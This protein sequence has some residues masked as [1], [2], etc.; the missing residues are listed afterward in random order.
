MADRE[1]EDKKQLIKILKNSKETQQLIEILKS[2]PNIIVYK[3]YTL[4][5]LS[6]GFDNGKWYIKHNNDGEFSFH[7]D[8]LADEIYNAGYQKIPDGAVVLTKEVVEFFVNHIAQVRKETVR[9]ILTKMFECINSFGVDYVDIREKLK[10]I[11]TREGV[12]IKE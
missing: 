3:P 9:E 6:E 7:Y 12:E 1:N 10:E 4:E 8:K 2:M 11:A 5:I